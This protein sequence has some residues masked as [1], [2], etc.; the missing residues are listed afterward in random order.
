MIIDEQTLN[1]ASTGHGSPIPIYDDGYGP[2]WIHRGSM[3]ITGIVR[4]RSW[5]DAYSLCEDEFFP[6]ADENEE[7]WIKE[8]G[9]DFVENPCW[10]EAFGFRNN[11]RNGSPIY[12]KDLNGDRLD[13]L[14]PELVGALGITLD[15]RDPE[16]EPE[17]P[18]RFHYW[19]ITRRTTG[20]RGVYVAAWAGR[21][22]AHSSTFACHKRRLPAHSPY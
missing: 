1:G 13:L 18:T 11:S 15:I 14:T 20:R 10:Q 22:G 17:P 5:Y 19:H 4:A 12:A 16:P 3:G 7:D 8:Y 9:E 2:L 6:D 21:Y